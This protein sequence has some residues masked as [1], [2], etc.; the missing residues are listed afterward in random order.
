MIALVLAH[1][2]LQGAAPSVQ[3]REPGMALAALLAASQVTISPSTPWPASTCVL[4]KSPQAPVQTVGALL[5]RQLAEFRGGRN[6]A[7][8]T[9]GSPAQGCK[10]SLL[11]ADGEDV[12]A[13]RISFRLK[14]GRVD[15]ATLLCEVT[16]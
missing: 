8:G 1:A 16:P 10:V 13:T 7:S 12:S 9:C 3:P 14:D 15:P 6:T 5:A 2:V 11:H 4:D